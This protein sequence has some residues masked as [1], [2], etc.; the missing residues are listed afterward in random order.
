[1]SW[2]LQKKNKS[3]FLK[4]TLSKGIFLTFVF[5]LDVECTE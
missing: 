5:Y 2:S 1:M 4:Y 3:I